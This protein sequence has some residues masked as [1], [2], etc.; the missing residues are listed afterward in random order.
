M[1]F[2]NIE[3]KDRVNSTGL[4]GSVLLCVG[5]GDRHSNQGSFVQIV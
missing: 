3:P 2:I 5:P 4:K 1:K